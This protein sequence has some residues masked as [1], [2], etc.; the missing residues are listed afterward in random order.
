MLLESYIYSWI[1][2]EKY[3]EKVFGRLAAKA[4]TSMARN[5]FRSLAEAGSRHAQMLQEGFANC[6]DEEKTAQIQIA[7]PPRDTEDC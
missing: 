4:E 6:S 2:V 7:L 5:I 3:T 1:E